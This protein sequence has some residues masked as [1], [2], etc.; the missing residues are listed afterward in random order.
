MYKKYGSS[1][2]LTATFVLTGSGYTNSKACTVTLKGNQ[3]TARIN[4]SNSWKRGKSYL[5]VND[6][7]KKCVIWKNVNGTWRRCI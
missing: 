3:K 2:S 6:A 1:S 4:V 5:K 7:W